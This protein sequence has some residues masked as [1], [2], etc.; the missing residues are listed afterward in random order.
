[1]NR[2]KILYAAGV[3]LIL[4][5]L[6]E[7]LSPYFVLFN[8]QI[9]IGIG[10]VSV[11]LVGFVLLQWVV[12]GGIHFV[13]KNIQ[14]PLTTA[15]RHRQRMQSE[16]EYMNKMM[17]KDVDKMEWEELNE[18]YEKLKSKQFL[19]E[20]LAVNYR[21][22][23]EHLEM[24]HTRIQDIEDIERDKEREQERKIH[25]QKIVELK[26][27]EETLQKTEEEV[28]DDKRNEF[29]GEY[30]DTWYVHTAYLNTQQQEWLQE[31]GFEKTHQ[32]DI[33]DKKNVEM[34]VRRR[35]NESHSHAYLVGAIWQHI[36]EEGIDPGAKMFN[37]KMPDV[38]F[39]V[40]GFE[41]AIEV[42]TGSQ[43]RKNSKIVHEKVAMLKENYNDRWFFV[44]ANKNLVSKYRK[45][46]DV[47]DRATVME[48]IWD[49]YDPEGIVRSEMATTV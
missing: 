7:V 21:K 42:E 13:E 27:Q 2:T 3:G 20:N 24:V 25:E 17:K 47:V 44:V 9:A 43:L 41:W 33:R 23:A 28:E 46:G 19:P 48:K 34:M 36:T 39:T 40:G 22:W 8:T 31:A 37:T 12:E 11:V 49:I 1:M 18:Y 15:K 45:F 30:K 32:W 35:S 38:V 4:A 26:Q 10:V 5:I 14:T 16:K 29:L 6:I